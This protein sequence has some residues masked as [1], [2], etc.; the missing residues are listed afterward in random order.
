MGAGG[1]GEEKDLGLPGE[2]PKECVAG[3]GGQDVS[4]PGS[5]LQEEQVVGNAQHQMAMISRWETQEKKGVRYNW[6]LRKV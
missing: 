2:E 1:G 6:L 3:E 5:D 4:S